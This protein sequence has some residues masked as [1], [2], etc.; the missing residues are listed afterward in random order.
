MYHSSVVILPTSKLIR[1]IFYK[2]YPYSSLC[3]TDKQLHL[4]SNLFYIEWDYDLKNS[5]N[6]SISSMNY[7]L[8]CWN[9]KPF[10]Q[11]ICVFYRKVL[12]QWRRCSI[13]KDY[14]NSSPPTKIL[15][16]FYMC[17]MVI[18]SIIQSLT[19]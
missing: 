18:D 8:I 12:L 4:Y 1:G 10:M 16:L 13:I 19:W 17:H 15:W 7:N 11:Y 2:K 6:L 3:S 14:W 9:C 5:L